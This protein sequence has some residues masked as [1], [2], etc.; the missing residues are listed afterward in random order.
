[1]YPFLAPCD[2]SMQ[3]ALQIGNDPLLLQSRT[4]LLAAAGLQA[5][6]LSGVAEALDRIPS[7]LWDAAI[8]CHTLSPRECAVVTAAL[9]RRNPCAPILFVARHSYPVPGEGEGCDLLLSSNPVRL[10]SALR[11][12]RQRR[13]EPAK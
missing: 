4:G 1:M 10:V 9:R 2:A 7:T 12:V 8:L 6:N 13:A 11:H 3:K 5:L